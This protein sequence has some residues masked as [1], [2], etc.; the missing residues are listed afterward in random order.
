MIFFPPRLTRLIMPFHYNGPLPSLPSSLTSLTLKN[1]RQVSG[2][3]VP[4]SI[5]DLGIL[6]LEELEEPEDDRHP[7]LRQAQFPASLVSLAIFALVTRRI[8]DVGFVPPSLVSF[9]LSCFNE[10]LRLGCLPSSLTVL[11]LPLAFRPP[12]PNLVLP[13]NLLELTSAVLFSPLPR[14]LKLLSLDG[15]DSLDDVTRIVVES[16]ARAPPFWPESL[17]EM[18][19]DIPQPIPRLFPLPPSL[20]SLKLGGSRHTRPSS[21]AYSLPPLPHSIRSL[22]LNQNFAPLSFSSLPSALTALEIRDS[23]NHPILPNMLPSSL[24]SLSL[25]AYFNR[26]LG[27]G[28]LPKSLT[29]LK[30]GEKFQQPL[31]LIS[32]PPELREFTVYHDYSYLPSLVCSPLFPCMDVNII[33]LRGG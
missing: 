12:S 16:M 24:R 14:R 3:I 11:N 9:T 32:F 1:F 21:D 17:T 30:L 18:T 4:S 20:V 19:I 7:S 22:V 10:P 23:L 15:F 29:S 5:T 6:E 28:V 33:D 2:G 27:P 25:G 31:S 13:D 26:P 8:L